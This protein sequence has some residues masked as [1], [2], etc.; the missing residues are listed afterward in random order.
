MSAAD[1]E[2][3][4]P[5]DAIVLGRRL[6]RR[7][8]EDATIPESDLY[9]NPDLAS[10]VGEIAHWVRDAGDLGTDGDSARYRDR[11]VQTLYN[12]ADTC[13]GSFAD[14]D[15]DADADAEEKEDD[16]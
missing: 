7:L 11:L 3:L 5:L 1:S 15:A 12:A 8:L 14:D 2:T 9:D 13:A 10:V 4:P 16:D 6:H